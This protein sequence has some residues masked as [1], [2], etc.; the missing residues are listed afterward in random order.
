[1]RRLAEAWAESGGAGT[2]TAWERCAAGVVSG[3]GGSA[4]DGCAST[5]VGERRRGS[6]TGVR[7]LKPDGCGEGVSAERA[8]GTAAEGTDL[9]VCGGVGCVVADAAVGCASTAEAVGRW[10]VKAKGA[11]AY[12]GCRDEGAP[13]DSASS[14]PA[15]A[16]G[17]SSG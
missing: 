10:G 17:T 15:E 2:G 9:W 14:A 3:K 7:A 4:A 1:M 11:G 13:N 12:A 6:K 8:V 16:T 5:A